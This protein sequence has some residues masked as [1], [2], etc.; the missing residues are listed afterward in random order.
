MKQI[1][2]GA[3]DKQGNVYPWVS[4][5]IYFVKNKKLVNQKPLV[6]NKKYKAAYVGLF[7][8][9]MIGNITESNTELYVEDHPEL[10]PVHLLVEME[11]TEKEKSDVGN[12]SIDSIVLKNKDITYLGEVK[13]P[14]VAYFRDRVGLQANNKQKEDNVNRALSYWDFI[15]RD[16]SDNEFYNVFFP[17]IMKFNN[18]KEKYRYDLDITDKNF[19]RVFY[20]VTKTAFDYHNYSFGTYGISRVSISGLKKFINKFKQTLTANDILTMV[21]ANMFNYDLDMFFSLTPAT[22]LIR[23]GLTAPLVNLITTTA[24]TIIEEHGIEEF[25]RL[26]LKGSLYS[27]VDF[28]GYFKERTDNFFKQDKLSIKEVL[29]VTLDENY[30]V[31]DN[32]YDEYQ[33]EY[34]YEFDY[35][36]GDDYEDY[37]YWEPEFD[38]QMTEMENIYG[39][40]PSIMYELLPDD[41]VTNLISKIASKSLIK[42][43]ME[44]RDV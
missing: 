30:E 14:L 26:N 12:G 19:E 38:E 43:I 17:I 25:N 9:K 2:I 6:K 34:D 35:P 33:S 31:P 36:W 20:L 13:E 23:K 40:S 37:D 32:T 41:Y 1:I 7:P 22:N 29:N 42:R 10:Q 28:R 11:F 27:L 44:E 5:Q 3:K 4:P 16:Y 8:F 39:F 15:R 18:N 24:L 21:K